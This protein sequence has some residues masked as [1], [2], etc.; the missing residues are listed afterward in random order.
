MGHCTADGK[1]YLS[2]FLVKQ[3][4]VCST[5]R[6]IAVPGRWYYLPMSR[7]K[8]DPNDATLSIRLK[9]KELETIKKAAKTQAIPISI[10]VRLT[11]MARSQR[12]LKRRP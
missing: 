1:N 2:R 7:F 12:I 5:G 9:P 11:M 4:P 3:Y 10:F 6:L 8:L